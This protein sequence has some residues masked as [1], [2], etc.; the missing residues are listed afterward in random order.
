[1]AF[2]AEVVIS[3][4][5]MSVILRFSNN[6]RLAHFTGLFAGAMIATYIS[7]EAPY[8]GMSMNPARTFASALPAQIWTALWLY[9]TAPPLGMLL[10]AELYVRQHGIHHVFCAKLYHHNNKRCI[11]HCNWKQLSAASGQLSVSDTWE[12]LISTDLSLLYWELTTEKFPGGSDVS[13]QSLRQKNFG[14]I[15]HYGGISPA[16]P[17]SYDDLELVL[18]SGRPASPTSLDH[19]CRSDWP[20]GK[21]HW[22]TWRFWPL[23]KTEFGDRNNCHRRRTHRYRC[24]T[25]H[26]AHQLFVRACRSWCAR[27]LPVIPVVSM[28]ASIVTMLLSQVKAGKRS[29]HP[30]AFNFP[31]PQAVDGVKIVIEGFWFDADGEKRNAMNQQTEEQQNSKS[32]TLSLFAHNDD[33]PATADSSAH[34]FSS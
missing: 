33:I 6:P 13:S 15:R 4:L 23:E 18:H 26:E 17:I 29:A 5:Q 16:W 10:A 3:F 34:F 9:F 1:V 7:L 14:E 27:S 8:S 25:R 20:V 11:F 24:S 32:F 22:R 19:F 12:M 30:C 28:F 21:R 31:V 2:L